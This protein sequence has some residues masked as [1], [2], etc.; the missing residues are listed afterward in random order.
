M[1]SLTIPSRLQVAKRRITAPNSPRQPPATAAFSMMNS[2]CTSGSTP[3]PATIRTMPI[4]GRPTALP[5]RKPAASE[6]H[7][8]L[9]ILPHPHQ[10]VSL[11]AP[12]DFEFG[13]AQD[14]SVSVWVKNGTG[15]PDNTGAGGGNNDPAIISNKDWNRGVLRGW[16][17]A[18]GGD[19]RWQWN[20]GDGAN[21]AGSTT[22]VRPDKSATGSGIT[23]P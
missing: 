18:A 14:F 19:G 9:W 2:C 6:A 10:Y 21:R 16:V 11:G 20:I 12:A 22:M 15:Y 7:T 1:V 23:S 17:I 5:P 3:G 13:T 8:H 4:T